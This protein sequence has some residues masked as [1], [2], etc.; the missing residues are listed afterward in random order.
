MNVRHHLHTH[1]TTII[2]GDEIANHIEII[3]R[4][5][6]DATNSRIFDQD[7]SPW[8]DF[9][10]LFEAFI[11]DVNVKRSN[12][13]HFIAHLRKMCTTHPEFYFQV[14]S[15]NVNVSPKKQIA[16]VFL[17]MDFEGMPPG[18][19]R[20]AV[21]T[22]SFR[23]VGEKWLCTKWTSLRGLVDGVEPVAV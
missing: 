10:P 19:V 14:T 7:Q 9:S 12:L 11:G 15:L 18:I 5:V 20:P 13:T 16:E 23:L 1:S 8:D 4:S 2:H 17:N 22:I 3:V 21:A 6:A